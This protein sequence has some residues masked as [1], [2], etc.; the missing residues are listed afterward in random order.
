MHII[1][2]FQKP[3]SEGVR[4]ISLAGDRRGFLFGTAA[5]FDRRLAVALFQIGKYDLKDEFL[6]S[7]VVEFDHDIL[8]VAGHD[9]A[10][11]EFR[12]FDL[13]ALGKGRFIGHG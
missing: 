5:F 12:V 13:S 1:G 11:P 10:E 2:S 8:V 3:V 7:V 9:A 6:L 4:R